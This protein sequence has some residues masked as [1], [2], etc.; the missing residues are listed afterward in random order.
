M[1]SKGGAIYD[2]KQAIT[3]GYTEIDRINADPNLTDRQKYEQTSAKRREMIETALAANEK[4]GEWMDKYVTGGNLVVNS[5]KAGAIAHKPTEAERM[6][7]VFRNDLSSGAEYMSLV[8]DVVD[9]NASEGHGWQ[10][11]YPHPATEYT[12]T[13]KL[14]GE[15]LTYTFTDEDKAVL[16]EIYRDEYQRYL[17]SKSLEW[18]TLDAKKKR[19]MLSSAHSAANKEMKKYFEKMMLPDIQ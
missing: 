11:L 12:Y 14:T 7:E 3:A 2:T 13:D 16:D 9:L 18:S 4:L 19:Q 8:Q 10:N 15:E 17:E 5:L 6:G 1:T